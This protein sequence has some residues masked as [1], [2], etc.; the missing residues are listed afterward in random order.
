MFICVYPWF[1]SAAMSFAGTPADNQEKLSVIG[2]KYLRSSA[3]ICGFILY[4]PWYRLKT[5]APLVPPNPK[6]LDKAYSIFMGRAWL[7]T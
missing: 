2:A 3:F 4:W 5:N 6:E 1:L 7:G